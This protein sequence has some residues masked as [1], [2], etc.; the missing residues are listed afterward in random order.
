VE[1]GKA[2]PLPTMAVV[3]D[4]PE[5]PEVYASFHRNRINKFPS[6]GRLILEAPERDASPWRHELDH[7]AESVFWLLLYWAM[8]VQPANS[9]DPSEKIDPSAWV[10]LLGDAMTRNH[11]LGTIV[12]YGVPSALTHSIYKPLCPLI[13]SLSSILIVDRQWLTESDVR[14][15]PTYISEAF[16]RLVLRFIL[17]NSQKEFMDCEAGI[18]FRSVKRMP[19]SNAQSATYSERL[20]AVLSAACSATMP[21]L[22]A[23]T[24]DTVDRK[25]ASSSSMDDA[26]WK[27]RRLAPPV[28]VCCQRG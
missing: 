3:P 15:N 2:V 27:R 14:N 25:R 17:D 21:T 9:D 19:K 18:Q 26:K 4:V 22:P 6:P 10:N 11:L 23:T 28:E 5:S 12:H 7:D 24:V 20:S 16:Q 1:T 8:V 13:A